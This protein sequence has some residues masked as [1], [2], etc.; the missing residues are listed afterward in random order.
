MSKIKSVAHFW[1]LLQGARGGAQSGGGGAHEKF[2]LACAVS[3]LLS[4]YIS[5]P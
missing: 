2:A 5:Q 3:S 4:M 1:D